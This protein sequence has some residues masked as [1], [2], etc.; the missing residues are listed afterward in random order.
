MT[1]G[2]VPNAPA[3]ERS[4]VGIGAIPVTAAPP[5]PFPDVVGAEGPDVVPDAAAVVELGEPGEFE[6]QAEVASSRAVPAAR[7]T[8]R[9]LEDRCLD[10][11]GRLV[12][13]IWR[14]ESLTP[15]CNRRTETDP[16]SRTRAIYVIGSGLEQA[17][18]ARTRTDR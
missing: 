14:D 13:L 1:V 6:E 5:D 2:R 10:M 15:W 17:L 18:R 11:A 12:P 9:P 8:R 7:R 3:G 16:L 4:A